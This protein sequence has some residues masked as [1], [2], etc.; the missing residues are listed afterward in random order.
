MQPW[1]AYD[2]SLFFNCSVYIYFCLKTV[3]NTVSGHQ[4]MNP[5]I[6]QTTLFQTNGGKSSVYNQRL[7]VCTCML[8]NV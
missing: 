2:T 8:F 1:W 5:V 6:I 4:E 7:Y 3:T